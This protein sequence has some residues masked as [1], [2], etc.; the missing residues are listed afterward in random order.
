MFLLDYT[1]DAARIDEHWINKTQISCFT[2]TNDDISAV[3]PAPYLF[4]RVR[5]FW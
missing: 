5:Y 4:T 1:M 2:V 3:F